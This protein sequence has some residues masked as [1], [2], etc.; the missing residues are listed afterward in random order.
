MTIKNLIIA[1]VLLMFLA[2]PVNAAEA[3]SGE[4]QLVGGFEKSFSPERQ[5]L[6]SSSRGH[7]GGAV[8]GNMVAEGFDLIDG[9]W[10][11]SGKDDSSG[12]LSTALLLIVSPVYW[13]MTALILAGKSRR[14]NPRRWAVGAGFGSFFIFPLLALVLYL[15][16]AGAE[17]TRIIPKIAVG[18]LKTL[19][20]IL[21]WAAGCLILIVVYSIA[22][23]GHL[24]PWI[25]GLV[26]A[27]AIL[28]FGLRKYFLNSRRPVQMPESASRPSE[29]F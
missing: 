2:V 25:Y 22:L 4:N 7:G 13:A 27:A 21:I 23:Y 26:A 14:R 12:E 11:R 16:V 10:S 17:K 20:V 28:G 15:S 6:N 29:R 24:A 3:F 8:V 5:T 18:L 9:L 1:A 19:K